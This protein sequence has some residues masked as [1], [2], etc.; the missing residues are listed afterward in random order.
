M[1]PSA[2]YRFTFTST[3]S[4]G[5]PHEKPE[6]QLAEVE[7]RDEEGRSIL[8]KGTIARNP[9]GGLISPQQT[10]SH[11]IDQ[12][13]QT[14]WLDGNFKANGGR[15]VLELTLP[16]ARSLASYNLYTANDVVQRDPTSWTLQ[17]RTASDTWVVVDE[18]QIQAPADRL[19][20]YSMTG[21]AVAEKHFVQPGWSGDSQPLSSHSSSSP[22]S[23]WPPPTQG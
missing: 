9:D 4:L 20:A 23:P 13:L 5:G 3:S 22:P 6:L 18:Q 14:K 19:A 1:T 8:E 21:F 7:M 16:T 2:G 12:R 15:S 17:I 11:A 10:A